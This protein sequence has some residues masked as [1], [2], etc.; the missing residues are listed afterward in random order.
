M[1]T[2]SR[3]TQKGGKRREFTVKLS[4]CSCLPPAELSVG[5]CPRLVSSGPV[6]QVK[7]VGR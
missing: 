3:P 6:D 1:A 7:A 5:N 4:V 2:E